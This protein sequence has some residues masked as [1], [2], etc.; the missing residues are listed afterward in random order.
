[1]HSVKTGETAFDNLYGMNWFEYVAQNPEPSEIFNDA[2]T[3]FATQIHTAAV[4]A[5]DVMLRGRPYRPNRYRPKSSLAE[6]FQ[7]LRREAGRQFDVRVVEAMG[8]LLGDPKASS[9]D[10]PRTH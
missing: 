4:D 6:A 2:M 10:S 5:Y 7:E 9:R 1:M 8:R 3:G